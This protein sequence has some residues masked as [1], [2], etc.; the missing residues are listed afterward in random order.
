[1]TAEVGVNFAFTKLSGEDAYTAPV[2]IKPALKV[3][4]V[5][6]MGDSDFIPAEEAATAS[7]Y[8]PVAATAATAV[9]GGSAALA[10]ARE[11]TYESLATAAW[12][13]P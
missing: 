9:T 7:P 8:R 4:R 6:L 1:M 13:L 2:V 11:L 5:Q 10:A 12:D 3:L